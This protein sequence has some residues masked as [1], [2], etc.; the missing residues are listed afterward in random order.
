VRERGREDR[1]GKEKAPSPPP[2]PTRALSEPSVSA[3]GV[4]RADVSADDGDDQ[5]ESV[6]SAVDAVVPFR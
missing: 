5:A 4:A 3:A 2:P 6:C 1:G